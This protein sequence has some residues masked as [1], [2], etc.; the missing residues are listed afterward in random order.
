MVLSNVKVSVPL[1]LKL[2]DIWIA[3]TVSIVY[4]LQCTTQRP[5]MSSHSHFP[6]RLLWLAVQ[7]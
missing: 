5:D 2:L 1:L 6:D 4:T 3:H 7:T